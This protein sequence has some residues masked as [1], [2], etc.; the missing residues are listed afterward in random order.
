[1]QSWYDWRNSG[2][3]LGYGFTSGINRISKQKVCY[4]LHT[5]SDITWDSFVWYIAD[6]CDIEDFGEDWISIRLVSAKQREFFYKKVMEYSEE[7]CASNFEI[8]REN[9]LW[10]D[11]KKGADRNRNILLRLIK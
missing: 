3:D 10:K 7:I 8:D 2:M 6:Y 5:D 4:W 11:H 9:E 1:M